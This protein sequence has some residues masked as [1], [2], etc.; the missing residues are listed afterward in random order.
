ME[1]E[2]CGRKFKPDS[3][4]K[5]K[6]LCMKDPSHFKRAPPKKEAPPPPEESIRV[7]SKGYNLSAALQDDG[8][9]DVRLVPCRLCG[10]NFAEDRVAKHEKACKGP[11]KAPEPKHTEPPKKKP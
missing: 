8:G 6:K 11:G 1:C 2:G 4:V 3:L 10:R 5:H 9:M 7:P